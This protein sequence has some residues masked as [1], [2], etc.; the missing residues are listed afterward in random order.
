MRTWLIGIVAG[1]VVLGSLA[2]SRSKQNTAHQP[3][4]SA[5]PD[6]HERLTQAAISASRNVGLHE[7]VIAWSEQ[8][9]I[10]RCSGDSQP[11]S[12]DGFYCNI[13]AYNS[14]FRYEAQAMGA[15]HVVEGTVAKL[16]GVEMRVA[17]DKSEYHIWVSFPA[18]NN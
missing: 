15:C 8:L 13:H 9:E 16:D 2:C 1:S 12:D 10:T 7:A 6:I 18:E 3:E 14:A 11:C 17:G 4:G 5:K